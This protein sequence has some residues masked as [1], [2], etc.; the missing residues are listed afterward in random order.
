MKL[1][2]GI[3]ALAMTA[4]T[5][6]AQ[7][8]ASII[9]NTKNSL[10]GAQQKQTAASNEALQGMGTPSKPSA[11]TASNKPAPPQ[12]KPAL[13]PAAATQTPKV[14]PAKT[15]PTP[16]KVAPA[17]VKTTPAPAPA[18]L[19][20]MA[21]K[22]PPAPV[23]TAPAPVAPKVAA[24]P[25]APV[26]LPATTAPATAVAAPAPKP[27]KS[28][29][30]KYSMTGK[31]DPFI[32]PVVSRT[33]GSGCS[34]GKKCL[35]IEQIAVRGVVKADN[36]MI[37]VVTNGLNKAYFLREN[38]PVFNGYVVKITVDSVVFKQN[39]QDRLG[40]PFTKDVVKRITT[41]AA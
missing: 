41:P 21:V 37:A 14:A 13:V 25:A 33:G 3:V 31:R 29:E 7:N 35:D 16:V 26:T 27:A 10:Q 2:T 32:S 11:A 1:T 20:P 36:G 39:F 15:V 28:E 17:V 40:K 19:A 8:P 18:K 5:L 30:K 12:L 23:K 22:T 38:D 24:K 9:Q 6:W 34:T 4:G